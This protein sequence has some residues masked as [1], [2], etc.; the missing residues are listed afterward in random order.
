MGGAVKPGQTIQGKGTGTVQ[1]SRPTLTQP[2]QVS[3]LPPQ[4]GKGGAQNPDG[5]RTGTLPGYAQPYVNSMLNQP[6]VPAQGGKGGVQPPEMTQDR[7][8]KL[9]EMERM[10]RQGSQ[11]PSQGGKA[12]ITLP[13]GV[14]GKPGVPSQLGNLNL[15]SML[16][17]GGGQQP[18]NPISPYNEW[19][20]GQNNPIDPKTGAN[21]LITQ[22]FERM[23][24]DY[25]GLPANAQFEGQT[26]I[27]GF[28]Q[29]QVQQPAPVM[30]RPV[31]PRPV[32]PRPAI[33][34]ANQLRAA[35]AP[36]PATPRPSG[37]QPS[38]ASQ[39]GGLGLGSLGL[40]RGNM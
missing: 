32:M 3:T 16:Y 18:K 23:Y 36:Q 20:Q 33:R 9:A 28:G 8:A 30:P 12:P 17:G 7:A 35:Y 26:P 1:P 6:Q 5:T 24:R 31:M 13:P 29:P 39:V 4:G 37:P 15:G 38:I 21:T 27:G 22:D 25:A 14:E 11:V 10:M 2:G 40:F 19:I 34:S